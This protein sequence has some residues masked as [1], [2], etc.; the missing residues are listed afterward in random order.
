MPSCVEGRGVLNETTIDG[1]TVAG[2]PTDSELAALRERGFA[3]V[4]SNRPSDELDE[5]EAPKIPAGVRYVEVPFTRA[6]LAD[7][8]VRAVEE[9]LESSDGPVLVHCAGG[10]RAAIVVAAALAKRRGLDAERAL[11]MV[12]EAGFEPGAYEGFV[13]RYLA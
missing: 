12:R 11:A 8:H 13:R 10:T 1:I 7:A 2:Q 9:A 5:P 6:T 3:T 4:I